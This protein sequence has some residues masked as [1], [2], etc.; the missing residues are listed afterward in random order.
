MLEKGPNGMIW[1][2]MFAPVPIKNLVVEPVAVWITASSGW[3]VDGVMNFDAMTL[4]VEVVMMNTSN[5]D[6]SVL[7]GVVEVHVG[8]VPLG[9]LSHQGAMAK[10]ATM[11]HSITGTINAKDSQAAQALFDCINAQNPSINPVV[12]VM[13]T[14]DFH[15]PLSGPL[16]RMTVANQP[17]SIKNLT[18]N[19]RSG[20]PVRTHAEV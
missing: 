7:A 10:G 20:S 1:R 18:I 12:A 3:T 17:V 2:P 11:S 19:R 8:Q 4:T 15:M 5:R 6:L 14:G 16:G 9:T 13:V